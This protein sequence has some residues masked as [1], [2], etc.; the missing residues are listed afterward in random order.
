MFFYNPHIT[1]YYNPLYKAQPTKVFFVAH[2]G[3]YRPY[4][5]NHSFLQ[6]FGASHLELPFGWGSLYSNG[7]VQKTHWN[8]MN[9]EILIGLWPG[10]LFHGVWNNPYVSAWVLF[11]SL[12]TSNNQNFAHMKEHLLTWKRLNITS[13][14]FQ[15]SQKI[16][17]KLDHF[18]R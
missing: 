2:L 4:Q 15:P 1:G 13:W 16:F 10:S 3:P 8:D 14:W 7:N 17:V 18:S 9:H 12:Y 6:F 5:T 11:H